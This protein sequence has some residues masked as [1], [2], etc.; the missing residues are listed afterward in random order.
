MLLLGLLVA[1]LGRG[2]APSNPLQLRNLFQRKRSG[3][4]AGLASTILAAIIQQFRVALHPNYFIHNPLYH[5][6]QARR[7]S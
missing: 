6:V 7:Y 2:L 4:S 1:V 5:V 3:G